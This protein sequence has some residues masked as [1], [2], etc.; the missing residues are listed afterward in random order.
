MCKIIR[1]CTVCVIIALFFYSCEGETPEAEDQSGGQG[2]KTEETEEDEKV[3]EKSFFA[4]DLTTETEKP[5]KLTA[6]L[7]AEGKY[8]NVWVEKSTPNGKETAQKTAEVY[9]SKIYPKMLNAFDGVD[10]TEYPNN[11]GALNNIMDYADALT[12]KNKKL[13]I[14]FLDIKD[15]YKKGV[16]NGYTGG[17]FS[18]EDFFSVEDFPDSNEQDMIYIDTYPTFEFGMEGA[19]ETLAH[20]M[21]HLMNFT[22]SWVKRL[23]DNEI[24]TMDL[25]INE[26]LSSAAEYIYRGNN[27]NSKRLA[28]FNEDREQTIASGNNFY[29]WGDKSRSILDEYATVYMFFQWLRIHKGVEIYKKII[30]SEEWDYKA[31]VN[32][33]N[34][35]AGTTMQWEDILKSWFAANRFKNATGLYGYK[36]ESDF[37][38]ITTRFAPAGPTITLLPGEGVYS[39]VVTGGKS[40]EEYCTESSG[41]NIK[42]AGLSGN[43]ISEATTTAG[44]ALL[45]FN[46]NTSQDQ[47]DADLETGNLT[48]EAPAEPEQSLLF[49]IAAN[50]GGGGPFRIEARDILALN[51]ASRDGGGGGDPA[52]FNRRQM[53]DFQ[54]K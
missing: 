19:Y 20:E 1:K 36:G 30:V 6:E 11:L 8:C 3:E 52:K 38:G 25:W 21:Q 32:A 31:V 10:K 33:F 39:A 29:I 15:G 23:Y 43:A 9:D 34:A 53:H 13:T 48:N 45:T 2:E 22:T 7:L 12:D 51:K 28:W 47:V 44:G 27:K 24:C 54:N 49:N 5:Y 16:N 42:Y 50:A 4:Q 40:I 26:G 46:S 37:N 41:P 18:P 35:G 17:Y 14:L